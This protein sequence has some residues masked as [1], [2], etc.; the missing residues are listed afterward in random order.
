[1]IIHFGLEFDD[2][3]FPQH[4]TP[5]HNFL[6]IGPSGL[7][8][9]LELYLGLSGYPGNTEF[10]RIEMFRQIL[11]AQLNLDKALFYNNSFDSDP[12]ATA[13]RMLQMRDELLLE[14]WDFEQ[15]KKASKRLQ[16]FASIEESLQK[17]WSN[18]FPKGF[19]DRFIDVIEKLETR[20]HPIKE[21]HLNE[22]L[23]M[24]PGHFQHIFNKLKETGVTIAHLPKP[25]LSAASDLR[26]FQDLVLQSKTVDKT[27]KNDGSLILVYAKRETDAASFIA[28]VLKQN[29]ALQPLCLIPEKNRALDSALIEEGLPSLGILSAS[30][31]RPS[32]QIL[33]LISAFL[34]KPLDPFKVLEFVTM[35]IKPLAD[36]L[37]FEIARTIAEKPGIKSQAWFAMVAKYFDNLKE[38]AKTDKKIKYRKID[39][40][41]KFW[42]DRK[43]YPIT[44]VAPKEEILEIFEY[45]AKWA[46]QA[47]EETGSKNNSLIVL[48]EQASR[49]T[50]LLEALPEKETHLTA[51]K[52]ERIVRTIYEPSPIIFKETQIG[53]YPF[54]YN[55][56]AITTSTNQLIWWNFIKKDQEQ[57]FSN[58]YKDEIQYL[59]D[60]S[61]HLQSPAQQNQLMLWQRVR[62]ILLTKKQLILI[63]PSYVNG[64]EKHPNPLHDELQAGFENLDAISFHLSDERGKK[65]L[66]AH[67]KLPVKKQIDQYE[68]GRPVPFVKINQKEKITQREEETYSSLESLFYFPYQWVFRHKIKL[69]PSSILSVTKDNTLRGNLAHRLIERMLKEQF[70]KWKKQ[71]VE[72]WIDK[73]IDSLLDQEGSV[74]LMYGQ[75]PERI[76]F[77]NKMKYAC[78]ALVNLI[79]KNRWKVVETEMKLEGTF[80]NVPIKAKADLVLERGG[81]FAVVDFKWRGDRRRREALLNKEDL[82]LVMYSKLLEN[83]EKWAHTAFFILENGKMIARNNHA[84]AEAETVAQDAEHIAI[85][86]EIWDKME[87]TY[88]WRIKQLKAGNIE[89]RT[90]QT[91]DELEEAYGDLLGMDLL[92]MKSESSPFDA[93]RTLI[94]LIE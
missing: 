78:W 29:K 89:I 36:N 13:S 37:A 73:K 11:L 88:Q 54:I 70:Y 15:D 19:A 63:I 65:Q 60:K 46:V 72:Q 93:Y 17:N 71:D 66:E 9:Q 64:T 41:Y 90:Q 44:S 12:L 69:Y 22:P 47:F 33:K 57:F 40:Q 31:A 30:Q 67:L 68:L 10:L 4:K 32:L 2:R 23:E 56:S 79:V 35:P 53:H 39:K 52:L 75:E 84:F 83:K 8:Q 55:N 42:F 49:V 34:W 1:M 43:R 27:L 45:L 85:Y 58:W 51:L 80:M 86:E 6:Q 74:L 94:N 87:K 77:I 61:I 16:V 3:V 62:P 14:G 48:G 5:T 24:L 76:S 50:E 82:Q 59:S 20:K 7:L 91:V 28:N 92:E 26:S 21:I 18:E 81:E 25:E 38:K